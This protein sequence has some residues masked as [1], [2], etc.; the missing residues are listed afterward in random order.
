MRSRLVI[1]GLLGVIVTALILT[2]LTY[3]RSLGSHEAVRRFEM[4]FTDL[5]RLDVHHFEVHLTLVN[6][7]DVAVVVE[8][9]VV[10]LRLEDRL[11][12]SRNLYPEDLVIGP[13]GELGLNQELVSNLT[14]D[15]LPAP[16]A[17]IPRDDW[18][19]RVYF[20]MTHPVRE[21]EI[22]LHRQSTLSP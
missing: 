2:G 3:H 11:L 17:E 4:H 20:R 13:G 15:Q 16:G 5:D 22:S 21:G 6:G 9:M 19:V 1:V 7:G 18:S 12:A 14:G 8:S 10:M